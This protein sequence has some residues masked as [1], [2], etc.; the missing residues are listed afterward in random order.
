MANGDI[1]YSR[2]NFGTIQQQFF[3]IFQFLKGGVFP[4]PLVNKGEK[5]NIGTQGVNRVI[6][7]AH[8]FCWQMGWHWLGDLYLIETVRLI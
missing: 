2:L 4:P 8:L 5:K 1:F 3:G 6:R 7:A